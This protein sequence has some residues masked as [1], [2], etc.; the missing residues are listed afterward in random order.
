MGDCIGRLVATG[1]ERAIMGKVAGWT[2]QL[3]VLEGGITSTPRTCVSDRSN[4]RGHLTIGK[5]GFLHSPGA[6]A[7]G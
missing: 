6:S 3:L 5:I 4:R 2:S 7:R 1:V